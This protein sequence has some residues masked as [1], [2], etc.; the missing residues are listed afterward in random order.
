MVYNVRYHCLLAIQRH[1][2]CVCT[3]WNTTVITIRR[4]HRKKDPHHSSLGVYLNDINIIH[5]HHS[6]LNLLR[7]GKDIVLVGI[8]LYN[9]EYL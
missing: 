6:C 3:I 8:I 1:I 2:R 9:Y 5:L 7:L 4:E